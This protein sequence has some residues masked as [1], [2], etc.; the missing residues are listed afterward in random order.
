MV[1]G[2][3]IVPKKEMLLPC[4]KTIALRAVLQAEVQSMHDA[5]MA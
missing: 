3:S 2:Y 1:V 4:L 5:I